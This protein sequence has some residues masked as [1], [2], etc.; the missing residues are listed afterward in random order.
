MGEKKNT[1][2]WPVLEKWKNNI[3]LA[4]SSPRRA[5]IFRQ[6]GITFK[7]IASKIEEKAEDGE[8]PPAYAKRLAVSKA[9]SVLLNHRQSIVIGCDTLVVLKGKIL[10]KPKDID[11]ARIMLL[12]LSGKEHAVCSAVAIATKNDVYAATDSTR[13]F[14]RTIKEEELEWYLNSGEPMDKAGAYA[15]QGKGGV[16]VKKIEGCYYNVV[17]FPLSRFVTL[18]EEVKIS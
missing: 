16:F 9:R 2:L 15:I 7:Q 1:C 11:D 18:L 3:I 4:S 14:F 12:R 13:V 8:E 6:I 5:A 17:G 10:E